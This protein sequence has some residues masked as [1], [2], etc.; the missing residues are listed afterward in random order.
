MTDAPTTSE[1]YK[2]SVREALSDSESDSS[3][4][5]TSLFELQVFLTLVALGLGGIFFTLLTFGTVVCVTALIRRSNAAERPSAA[6]VLQQR[7]LAPMY[8]VEMHGNPVSHLNANAPHQQ[9][10]VIPNEGTLDQVE[11]ARAMQAEVKR[12]LSNEM[13]DR[14]LSVLARLETACAR[15]S[16]KQLQGVDDDFKSEGFSDHSVLTDSHDDDSMPHPKR[17]V[18]QQQHL[19]AVAGPRQMA[20]APAPAPP[21]PAPATFAAASK[22][23]TTGTSQSTGKIVR[24]VTDVVIMLYDTLRDRSHRTPSAFPL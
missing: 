15:L 12:Q 22:V 17:L 13:S 24:I 8:E 2:A 14:H 4:S 20:A 3:G 6:D 7:S 9:A 23:W 11:M 5:G 21:A 19:S 18:L 1:Q 10:A 16:V